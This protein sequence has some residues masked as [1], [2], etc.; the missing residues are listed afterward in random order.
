[1]G[2]PGSPLGERMLLR[3]RLPRFKR[4]VSP[5]RRVRPSQVERGASGVRPLPPF[6]AESMYQ[7]RAIDFVL[8]C[9]EGAERFVWKQYSIKRAG[10]EERFS[11]KNFAFW[12]LQ[13]GLVGAGRRDFFKCKEIRSGKPICRIIRISVQPKDS[14]CVPKIEPF[15]KCIV[16]FRFLGKDHDR[17]FRRTMRAAENRTAA[18]GLAFPC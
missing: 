6:A 10:W 4:M 5:G 16:S 1:M 9:S 13:R 12:I 7:M 15:R 3:K 8:S 2:A 14:V 17:L 18:L 11:G